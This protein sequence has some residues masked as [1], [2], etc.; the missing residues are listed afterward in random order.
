MVHIH[1]TR[2]EKHSRP[3][4]ILT[5]TAT[6]CN[7]LQHT[8]THCNTGMLIHDKFV[9]FPNGLGVLLSALT[10][11][12]FLVYPPPRLDVFK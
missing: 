12:L 5:Q 6:H 8:A 7:T 10:F 3:V 4:R 9:Y 1:P 11:S 2:I